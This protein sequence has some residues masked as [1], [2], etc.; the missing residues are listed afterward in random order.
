[1]ETLVN[2]N[3]T[4]VLISSALFV[5]EKGKR[6]GEVIPFRLERLLKSIRSWSSYGYSE[7]VIADNT[8]PANFNPVAILPLDLIKQHSI[9]FLPSRQS[10]TPLASAVPFDENEFKVNGPSRLEA[11]LLAQILPQLKPMLE[12]KAFVLKVSAGYTIA[13]FSSIA[14]PMKE[15][16]AVFR[17]GN[18]LRTRVKF[19]LT[20][21][22]CIPTHHFIA[23]VQHFQ[24]HVEE[25]NNRKPLEYYFYTYIQA[26]RRQTLYL[27]YP[28]IRAF[29][30][31]A[32]QSSE[33][34]AYRWKE[35]VF[36]LLSKTG[37]YAF[38]LL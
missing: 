37:Y 1:M 3:H 17:M 25:M 32:G 18:P 24:R 6:G 20:S 33:S 27:P 10:D 19:C 36:D 8:L 13:N 12:K 9:T 26:Q 2:T 35:R 14:Q 22:Y 23:L 5:D 31:A 30:L 29:F 28:K 15:G 21:F 38:R 4:L 11:V 16:G 7:I 34:T